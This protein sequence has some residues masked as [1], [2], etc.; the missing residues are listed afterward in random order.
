M[1]NCPPMIWHRPPDRPAWAKP[2][3]QFCVVLHV[4]A[5]SIG[6]QI[7]RIR[8][9]VELVMLV[10][11]WKDS[12]KTAHRNGGQQC[13]HPGGVV[14]R[15]H[16]EGAA[17]EE[18]AVSVGALLRH[19]RPVTGRELDAVALELLRAGGRRRCG[20]QLLSALAAWTTNALI[21][22]S[23]VDL[24]HWGHVRAAASDP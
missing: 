1:Q 13:R 16:P 5:P 8:R 7:G 12:R 10:S 22:T 15:L 20:S 21:G 6:C 23:V 18:I 19:R 3:P 9:G 24:K 2:A 4:N 11:S 14:H 17:H